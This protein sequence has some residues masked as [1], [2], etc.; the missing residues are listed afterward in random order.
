[1][2]SATST[3]DVRSCGARAMPS[4]RQRPALP[5][6]FTC[7]REGVV[8]WPRGAARNGLGWRSA[9]RRA[10]GAPTASRGGCA[11]PTAARATAAATPLARMGT[12]R[13]EARFRGFAGRADASAAS[14][15]SARGDF[16]LTD[17]R[18]AACSRGSRRLRLQRS[19]ARGGVAP[20]RDGLAARQGTAPEGDDEALVG[21]ASGRLRGQRALG[22]QG[23][24]DPSRARRH[25]RR[26]GSRR[27]RR[28]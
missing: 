3:Y 18:R 27:A 9:R 16:T 21:R 22:S 26:G 17:A 12:A 20:A 11:R 14:H 13:V 24:T 6:S 1:M 7:G 8:V 28:R 5:V 4:T 23:R 2:K 10:A 25:P 19:D 15:S